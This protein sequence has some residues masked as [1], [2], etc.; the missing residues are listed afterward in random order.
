[1][2][3]KQETLKDLYNDTFLEQHA[4]SK[5]LVFIKAKANFE[6]NR[7]ILSSLS[8]THKNLVVFVL[9]ENQC[10][11]NVEQH[12]KDYR[13]KMSESRII[14][15]KARTNNSIFEL[16]SFLDEANYKYDNVMVLGEFN[17]LCK[18]DVLLSLTAFN[19][20]SIGV[21]IDNDYFIY[22]KEALTKCNKKML[23]TDL[24]N[25]LDM[26]GMKIF[27][28]R[29]YKSQTDTTRANSKEIAKIGGI[30]GK[31]E[32][33]GLRKMINKIPKRL[34]SK[35]VWLSFAGVLTLALFQFGIITDVQT[36]S[37]E[38]LVSLSLDTLVL[39]GV[40]NNPTD[41]EKF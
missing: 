7:A 23:F 31:E 15:Y 13:K 34:K 20:K 41:R 17:E 4:D 9:I 36:T 22:S 38:K 2:C 6:I 40:L 28:N 25:T 37:I 3:S 10:K 39:F 35:V 16:V 19:D 14:I 33:G 27:L 30:S 11:V 26:N 21:I 24:E 1:M 18:E 29:E 5:V 32:I 8:Q 12:V